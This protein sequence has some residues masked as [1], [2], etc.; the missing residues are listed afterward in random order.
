MIITIKEEPMSGTT[1]QPIEE[2]SNLLTQTLT[3][4]SDLLSDI[5]QQINEFSD[6]SPEKEFLL[7]QRLG[8]LTGDITQFVE[9]TTLLSKLF[10]NKFKVTVPDIKNSHI[11]LLFILK[12]VNHARQ[13]QDFLVLEDLIKYELKD[14]L[15]Q[16]K[17]DLIPKMK[18]LIGL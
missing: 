17:I 13:K 1:S 5:I 10:I 18:K 9:L 14:N 8:F 2:V 11:H 12:A 4:S 6:F 15:T 7:N 3:I 16:W